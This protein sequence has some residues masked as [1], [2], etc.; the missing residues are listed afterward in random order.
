MSGLRAAILSIGDELVFGETLD[1]N[2]AWLSERLA[3]LG[4]ATIE[5]PTVGDELAEIAEAYRS[6]AARG[7]LVIS[8]GGLGPTVDDLTPEAMAIT[9]LSAPPSSTPTTSSVV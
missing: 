4:V 2:S 8:T 1:R 7:S 9:F 6:L 3:S 5:H